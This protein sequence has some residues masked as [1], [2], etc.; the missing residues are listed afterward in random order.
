M[1]TRARN[2]LAGKV[3]SVQPGVVNAEVIID[4][5]GGLSLVAIVTR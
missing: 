2:Q 1:K 5:G 3:A 4:A